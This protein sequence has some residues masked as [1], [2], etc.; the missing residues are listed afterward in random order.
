MLPTRAYADIPRLSPGPNAGPT[1]RPQGDTR[2]ALVVA[3]AAADVEKFPA[4]T[5]TRYPVHT[6]TEAL[7]LIETA[8]PRVVAVD[9]DVP[10]IDGTQV[11]A[12]ALKF[13]LTGVL[14]TMSA[15]ETAPA[16]LKAGCHAIL[17]KPFAPNLLVA[18]I[19]RLSRELPATP[20]AMRAARAMHQCGTNR[21]WPDTHCPTCAAPSATSF[22]FYSYRRMWYA[23]LSCDA[24]WLGP[25]QE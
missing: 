10:E 17:L 16:A 7:R 1:P 19:G 2:A 24:V 20:T 4:A 25:R 21:V 13:P 14:V 3:T 18:R 15:P 11:C 8:R 6:T 12:A 23:C 5:F 9:W 22:E